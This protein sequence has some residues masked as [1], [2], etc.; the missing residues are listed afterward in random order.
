M[1][2]ERRNSAN[3][4]RPSVLR[5]EA[6]A[7]CLWFHANAATLKGGM[8]CSLTKACTA[9]FSKRR[10]DVCC[11]IAYFLM[12]ESEEMKSGSR[13]QRIVYG[14]EYYACKL[15]CSVCVLMQMREC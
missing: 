1:E 15:E 8:N 11:D 12:T 14:K 5:L 2:T 10:Y 6:R 9:G 13:G 7:Q 3:G 4:V